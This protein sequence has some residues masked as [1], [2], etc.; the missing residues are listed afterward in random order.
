MELKNRAKGRKSS[1]A[2]PAKQKRR[3]GGPDLHESERALNSRE[4]H[5][6]GIAHTMV[7]SSGWEA[8]PRL[9]RRA[10]VGKAGCPPP[11]PGER[12]RH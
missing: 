5:M 12:K 4:E 6:G 7:A 3:V 1:E 11:S 9:V 8:A 10:T 2:T